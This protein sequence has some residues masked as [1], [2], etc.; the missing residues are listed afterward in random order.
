MVVCRAGATTLAELAAL[1]KPS[2]LIPY[3]YAAHQHQEVNARAVVA[4]G[5]ADMILEHELDGVGL[6]GRIKT[7]MENRDALEKMSASA[8]KAGMPRAK[9]IIADELFKLVK[10][11]CRQA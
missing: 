3:P 4:A 10:D 6:A 8:L 9:D 7:Y 5:G 2:I 11:N 1:G